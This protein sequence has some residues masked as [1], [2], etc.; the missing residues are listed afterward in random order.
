MTPR[1]LL[2]SLSAQGHSRTSAHRAAG[3]SWYTFRQLCAENPDIQWRQKGV[4]LSQYRAR[5]N[6]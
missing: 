4:H 3:I 1:D 5:S 6:P 2:K